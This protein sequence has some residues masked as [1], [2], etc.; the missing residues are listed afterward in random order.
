MLGYIGSIWRC[1]FFWLSLAKMDL[2]NRYR[3]SWLGLGW[4]L[5]HPVAMAAVLCTVF[6]R[7]FELDAKEFWMYLL[8]GLS[9][10]NFIAG[11]MIQGCHCFAQGESYIRQHR[12]PL[13]IYP[14][15]VVLASAFHLLVALSV[16][17]GASW[18]LHGWQVF[19][20]LPALVPALVLLVVLA[21][22]L[23]VVGGVLTVF[24]PDAQHLTEIGLSI[25]FYATP[26]IY[27]ND[28]LKEK[29]LG[30]LVDYNPLATFASLIRE[31]L[32]AGQ[33]PAWELYGNAALTA[34]VL[35]TAA[36]L[37]LARCER[38]LVFYL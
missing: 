37:I 8:A 21:W 26:I 13:A 17:L 33:A 15:R 12:A 20:A 35:A 18:F 36:A 22:S 34:L 25:L 31:P 3:R 28:L 38:R 2:Q 16:V 7:L 1:R 30:W 4:S 19:A 6:N 9:F 27:T 32:L 5:L 11:A 10:W 29:G 23:A 24:F 14:L